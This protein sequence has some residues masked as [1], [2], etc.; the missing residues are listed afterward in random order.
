MK[1]QEDC[2]TMN[3]FQKIKDENKELEVIFQD[4]EKIKGLIEWFDR[5]NIK[6]KLSDG[7]ECLIFKHFIKSYSSIRLT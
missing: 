1:K 2:S 4:G 5:W 7:S 3:Y 6:L